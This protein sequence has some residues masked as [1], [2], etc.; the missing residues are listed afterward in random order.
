[1]YIREE[2]GTNENRQ[3][4]FIYKMLIAN[5]LVCVKRCS[6]VCFFFISGEYEKGIFARGIAAEPP[7]GKC[8]A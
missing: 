4:T 8:E 2:I 3:P 5:V 1:M 6:M 7:K